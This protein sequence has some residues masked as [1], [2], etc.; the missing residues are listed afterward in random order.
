MAV[1]TSETI[2]IRKNQFEKSTVDFFEFFEE[3]A[4]PLQAEKTPLFARCFTSNEGYLRMS[5][6]FNITQQHLRRSRMTARL[7]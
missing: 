7:F 2:D 1:A 5:W 3:F 6:T 4:P